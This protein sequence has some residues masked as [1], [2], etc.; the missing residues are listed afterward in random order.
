MPSA[1]DPVLGSASVL[2]AS[3]GGSGTCRHH[4]SRALWYA[5]NT[6]LIQPAYLMSR[7]ALLALLAAAPLSAT[8]G[9]V[10]SKKVRGNRVSCIGDSTATSVNARAAVAN[11]VS[12]ACWLSG[13]A[14]LGINAAISGYT[15]VNLIS[16]QLPIILADPNGLP[17]LCFVAVGR[18][19]I[20]SGY[21]GISSGITPGSTRA[22]IALID[23]AL[24]TAGIDPIWVSVPPINNHPIGY[25]AVPNAIQL[26]QEL[27]AWLRDFCLKKKRT[28]IDRYTPFADPTTGQYK[29]GLSDDGVHP[30]YLAIP[31][32]ARLA[33]AVL[34][35]KLQSW[36]PPLVTSAV[37]ADNLI[38][39]GL[40]LDNTVFTGLPDKWTIKSGASNLGTALFSAIG[41]A[42]NAFRL[43][44]AAAGL[45]TGTVKSVTVACAPGQRL[46]WGFKAVCNGPGG[47]KAIGGSA[48]SLKYTFAR[49][50]VAAISS[51]R[52]IPIKGWQASLLDMATVWIEDVAPAGTTGFYDE[53][54]I[55]NSTGTLDIMQYTTRIIS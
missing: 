54:S 32:Q 19:D 29:V 52:L 9:S 22:N 36:S 20:S 35:N 45:A 34:D 28:Y 7:R 55:A 4:V 50:Y 43:Y 12:L 18:N 21:G 3:N 5:E 49:T 51:G 31:Y 17:D 30:S 42:G 11:W 41:A 38:K 10:G 1:Q 40:F 53:I 25:P 2:A 39:N 33:A 24:W 26:T 46:G 44:N 27:N 16:K 23:S 48:L 37:D 14:T 8:Q 15:T 13:R 47:P 6:P